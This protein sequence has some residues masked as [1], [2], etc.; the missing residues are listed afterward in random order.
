LTIAIKKAQN[1]HKAAEDYEKN[2]IRFFFKYV[3]RE[4][5]SV[6]TKDLRKSHLVKER[7]DSKIFY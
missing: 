7:D 5:I 2:A 6:K 4:N 3:I 1:Y